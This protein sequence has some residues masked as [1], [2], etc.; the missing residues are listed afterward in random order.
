MISIWS[1]HRMRQDNIIFSSFFFSNTTIAIPIHLPVVLVTRLDDGGTSIGVNHSMFN[2][3]QTFFQIHHQYF[4][5]VCFSLPFSFIFS[6]LFFYTLNQQNRSLFLF[7]WK[8]FSLFFYSVILPLTSIEYLHSSQ[9][10]NWMSRG[11]LYLEEHSRTSNCISLKSDLSSLND[12]WKMINL[13]E[14]ARILSRNHFQSLIIP[15][16]GMLSKVN[17]NPNKLHPNMIHHFSSRHHRSS[18]AAN[19][20]LSN[21][22]RTSSRTEETNLEVVCILCVQFD[23][24]KRK[25]TIVERW[26]RGGGEDSVYRFD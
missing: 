1:S 5:S 7:L 17:G 20:E 22:R 21:H 25:G 14:F 8:S 19:D 13:S 11:S 16:K 18:F 10:D 24:G 9:L 6:S 15:S 23:W 2:A 12:L 26:K 3:I 4:P